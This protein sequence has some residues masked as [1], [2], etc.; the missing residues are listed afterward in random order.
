MKTHNV[1]GRPPPRTHFC[2]QKKSKRSHRFFSLSSSGFST[3]I[4]K[5]VAEILHPHN[6]KR[7][8][9]FDSVTTCDHYLKRIFLFCFKNSGAKKYRKNWLQ[10]LQKLM[11]TNRGSGKKCWQ[12]FVLAKSSSKEQSGEL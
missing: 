1:K 4:E 8:K 11:T 5:P 2:N 7:Q 12:F 6:K 3:S 10:F 9:K